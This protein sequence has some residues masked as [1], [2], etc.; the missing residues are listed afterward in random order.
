[1]PNKDIFQIFVSTQFRQQYDEIYRD[2]LQYEL[3]RMNQQRMSSMT[4]ATNRDR[5]PQSPRAQSTHTNENMLLSKQLIE[6][7]KTLSMFLCDFIE[8]SCPHKWDLRELIGFER[9]LG[10]NPNLMM[11]KNSVFYEDVM[12]EFKSTLMYIGL[13]SDLI[14]LSILSFAFIDS[15]VLSERNS[16]VSILLTFI[17]DYS[18]ATVRS[19]FGERN[20]SQK[21]LIDQK[22]LL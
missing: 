4:N 9:F 3:K 6:S 1:L 15:V 11:E 20:V 14:I 5:V 8:K 17:I 2:V 16:I 7:S 21:T 18:L 12:V 10:P 19:Y 13:Q 22:F